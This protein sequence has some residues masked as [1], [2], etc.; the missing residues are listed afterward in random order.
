MKS[1]L[2]FLDSEGHRIRPANLAPRI[3]SLQ[4][5][6][7]Y[8]EIYVLNAKL[9]EAQVEATV[10]H[11][12][13]NDTLVGH[14]VAFDLAM[15]A[16]RFPHLLALIFRAYAENRITDTGI[17]QRLIDLAEGNLEGFMY[18]NGKNTK[19][20]YGLDFLAYR[21]ANVVLDKDTWR[22]R[23]N[24]LEDVPVSEWEPGAVDYAKG[25]VQ[26]ARVAYMHQE[27]IGRAAGYLRDEFRQARAAWWLHLQ[28]CWGMRTDGA[29]IDEWE[30]KIRARY[31][32]ARELVIAA[33]LLRVKGKKETKDTKAA[34]A[35]M[36]E[37]LGLNCP[38]TD[39]GEKKVKFE[40]A[41]VDLEFVRQYAALDEEACSDSGNPAL[42]AYAAFTSLGGMLSKDVPAVRQG[43]IYP[44]QPRFQ[45]LVSTGR[46]SC[47]GG[48]KDDGPLYTYQVQNLR[49]E[50][51]LRECFRARDGY[52]LISRD[53]IG[54]EL[55]T[56]SQCCITI[57]GFSD[58]AKALNAKIDPHLDFALDFMLHGM[59][60]E[61]ALK[62]K[63]EGHVKDARQAS[64]AG[65]FGLPGGLGANTFRQYA[66]AQYQ[67]ILDDDQA[68]ALI[69]GWK[70]KWSEGQAWLDYIARQMNRSTKRTTIEQ[71]FV[72]RIRGN[73]SFPEAAN[74]YFQGLAGDSAKAAGF[75]LAREAYTVKSSPLYGCRP[76]NFV[77]D[78]FIYEA[79]EDQ[80]HEAYMR[81]DEIMVEQGTRFCPDVPP[82][83][84][85]AMM[86]NWSKAAEEKTDPVTKRVIPYDERR[87]S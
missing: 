67:V 74:G 43:L 11:A 56:W 48:I 52:V 46:T 81:M 8:G 30:T 19:I 10:R 9:Q 50:P 33:G 61:E 32:T 72:G 40:G 83:T 36:V 37:A 75:E 66:K 3:V 26:W 47:A 84:E 2:F 15:L 63:K 17:R 69:R 44:I 62:R 34:K 7:D 68:K 29:R 41:T 4:F 60:Y 55:H 24:E 12:L 58:M 78:E 54:K 20:T 6:L 76:W 73:C 85:G 45:T 27:K 5:A 23:Y 18:L 49:R 14:N 31:A 53:Y 51:G 42:E 80:A 79:P 71:L 28:M 86:F 70:N 35:L 39:T 77:H 25:D 22:L 13:E 59:T 21:Y 16:V 38:L 57:L 1:Q 82:R 64:K 65:N 87:A